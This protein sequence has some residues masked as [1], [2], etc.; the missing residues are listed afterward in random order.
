MK[1]YIYQVLGNDQYKVIRV[2][3][4]KPHGKRLKEYHVDLKN[5]DWMCD[6]ES[7]YF[8]EKPCKHIKFIVSQLAAKGGILHFEQEGDYDKV[9]R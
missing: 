7:F 3:N 6:C 9:M 4:T 5:A 2:D 8:H 1:S